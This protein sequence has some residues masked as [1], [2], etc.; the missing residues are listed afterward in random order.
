MNVTIQQIFSIDII[1]DFGPSLQY[2][3]KCMETGA[4]Y[5]KAYSAASIETNLRLIKHFLKHLKPDYSNVKEA[6]I[7]T[8]IDTA[9]LKSKSQVRIYYAVVSYLKSLIEGGTNVN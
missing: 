3:L 6:Y 7:K 4:V 5:K 9:H 8:K 2:C 1:N